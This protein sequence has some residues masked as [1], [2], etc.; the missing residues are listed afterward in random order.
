MYLKNLLNKREISQKNIIDKFQK[1]EISI[2]R[3]F[4]LL[5][6][7]DTMKK[8]NTNFTIKNREN[9]E[10][11]N[12]EEILK[13]AI[14]EL[15]ELIGLKKIKNLIM[16]Y[17]S[18]LKVQKM[19][20]E[21][22]LKTEPIVLHMIFI[23]NPGTGKTTVAR[24]ISKIFKGLGVLEE[25]KL[26][27]VERADLVGEYIG[28]TAQKTKRLIN[29]ALGGVLF[30]DEA[31]SLSRGGEKDFGREA[32]DTIVKAMEDNKD[33]LIIILAGYKDEMRFF[34][35][36]NP[37]LR[38]RI[39]IHINFPDYSIDELV[40]IAE[41]MY[42]KKE[43]ILSKESKHYIYRALTYIISNEGTNSGNARTV[44]NFVE[45]SIRRQAKRIIEKRNINCNDL[46]LIKPEDMGQEV[47]KDD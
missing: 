22:G 29:K 8:D 19:R 47:V 46:I 40:K 14:E 36:A 38:S 24:I 32:I 18:F 13:N 26:L 16:E 33:K 31:Y 44:R 1:G 21:Y 27:E 7:L 35:N 39:A 5:T 43:Y 2:S 6:E 45:Y 41:F 9:N 25:D 42:S 30:I 28:H 37:G 11:E 3:A 4:K 12:N 17:I 15:E 20:E 34:L 23:G 10:L